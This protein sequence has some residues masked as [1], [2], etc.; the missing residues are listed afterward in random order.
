V[1]ACFRGN[2]VAAA[3]VADIVASVTASTAASAAHLLLVFFSSLR[4]APLSARVTLRWCCFLTF[5]FF[6]F[7]SLAVEDEDGDSQEMG[8]DDYDSMVRA[9]TSPCMFEKT[10]FAHLNPHLLDN[11]L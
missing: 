9:Q 1:L 7:F 4:R 11:T 3:T 10:F 5:T 8:F 2:A 6:L